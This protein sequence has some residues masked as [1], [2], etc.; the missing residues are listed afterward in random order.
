[1]KKGRVTSAVT[2][3]FAPMGERQKPQK[4]RVKTP[5]NIHGYNN[6]LV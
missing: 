4:F 3:I 1:M 2:Y 6:L 5:A